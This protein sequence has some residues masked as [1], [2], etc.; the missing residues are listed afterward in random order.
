MRQQK[1]RRMNEFREGDYFKVDR[2]E[3]VESF[4]DEDPIYDAIVGDMRL[5]IP[6]ALSC[7]VDIATGVVLKKEPMPGLFSHRSDFPYVWVPVRYD[8]RTK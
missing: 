2:F 5:P 4:R 6:Q 3:V 7:L 1:N 8:G